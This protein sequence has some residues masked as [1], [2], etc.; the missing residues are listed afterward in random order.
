MCVCVE[1]CVVVSPQDEDGRR[2]KVEL[3]GEEE[4][5]PSY[6]RLGRTGPAKSQTQR[7]ME[8]CGEEPIRQDDESNPEQV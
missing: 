7:V 3:P 4:E 2:Q 6:N 1:V 5:P 8:Q